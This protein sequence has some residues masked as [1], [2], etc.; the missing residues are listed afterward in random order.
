MDWIAVTQD[1]EKWRALVE[2]D[3]L[4]ASIK[5]VDFG[6]NL[7]ASHKGPCFMERQRKKR[8]SALGCEA[9]YRGAGKSLARQGREEAAPVKSATGRGMD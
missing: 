4:S 5:Y 7:L 8:D 2:E 1:K 9:L 3:E 6:E